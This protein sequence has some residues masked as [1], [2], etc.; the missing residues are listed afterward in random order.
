MRDFI[1]S[2]GCK[3]DARL[4]ILK[5]VKKNK[6]F[7]DTIKNILKNIYFNFGY[8]NSEHDLIKIFNDNDIIYVENANKEAANIKGTIKGI[9]EN[10]NNFVIFKNWEIKNYLQN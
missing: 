3:Q 10:N 2:D 6:I 5:E 9:A 1:V 7:H 8:F 4:L